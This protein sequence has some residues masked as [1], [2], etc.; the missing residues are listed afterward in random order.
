MTCFGLALLLAAARW[1]FPDAPY[2]AVFTLDKPA[3]DPSVGIAVNLPEFGN[4]TDKLLDVVMTDS[5]GELQPLAQVWRGGGQWVLLLAK[6]MKADQE[7]FVYFGGTRF[8]QGQTWQPQTSLLLETRQ[9]PGVRGIDSW[10]KMDAAWRNA[11]DVDGAGWETGI[12]HGANPYGENRH[13]LSRF[14]GLLRTENTA[15]LTLYTLSSDGSFVL[16][17]GK[18]EFGW[19]G[20]HNSQANAKN[21][22]TQSV[23]CAGPL[24][25]IDYYHAKTAGE[26]PAM[27]LGWKK[28]EKLET[29]PAS[30]WVHA[31]ATKMV[32][33]EQMQ[34]WPVPAPIL[35]VKSYIGYADLWLYEVTGKLR[36][37]LPAGWGVQWKFADGSTSTNKEFTRIAVGGDSVT[38]AVKLQNGNDVLT[39]TRQVKFLE[40]V[41]AASVRDAGDMRRYLAA[42]LGEN[43]GELPVGMLRNYFVFAE[44]TQQDAAAGQFAEAW[45]KR[46]PD[47]GDPLWLPAQLSRLRLLAQTD[48]RRAVEEL[49]RIPPAA[50]TRYAATL[51]LLE[52]DLLVFHLGD[53]AAVPR[54]QQIATQDPKS[55]TARLALV[56]AGDYYRLQGKYAEA[57]AQYQQA[58]KSVVE[59]SDGRK[60]PAQDRAYSITLN[61]LLERG[62]IDTAESKLTEWESR[63]PLAKL[64]SDF[65]ILRGRVLM[66]LGRWREALVEIESFEKLLPESPFQIDAAFYRARAL[67]EL[68]KKDEARKI[69]QTIAEKFPQHALAEKSRQWAGK[70]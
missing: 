40:Q 42:M 68:G 70:S 22:R 44:A 9:A 51:D 53:A 1:I 19:P 43:L 64:D 29:I 27:V 67:F 62:D 37:E 3:D 36:E 11:T 54:A 69:W 16:V 47:A 20:E 25:R 13:F 14:T 10:E 33:L 63:H 2:R 17:N 49:R 26:H 55:A 38:V 32:R 65:L 30:A 24:T 50:R 39:G 15:K 34:G 52:L 4:T 56:R 18:F 6:E 23:S 5:A 46:S 35:K 45:L 58:Q 31:G 48:A 41:P 60:L 61:D 57:A 12:N 21:V 59:G 8:R 7:Y 66:E 28:G